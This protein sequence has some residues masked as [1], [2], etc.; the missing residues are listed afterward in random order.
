MESKKSFARATVVKGSDQ[1]FNQVDPNHS[2]EWLNG[3]GEKGG[4]I[5]G[6]TKTTSAL[7]RWA[8]S[9][10]LRACIASKTRA[11]FMVG[12]D[13]QMIHN[14]TTPA[15]MKRDS[16]DE[17]KIVLVLQRMKVFAPDISCDISFSRIL[18]QKI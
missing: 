14:E 5:I 2:Q 16:G 17:D 6:I 8:L 3:T 11:L 4:D 12:H 18:L 10:N 7:S 15:R 13:D 9:H 1:R